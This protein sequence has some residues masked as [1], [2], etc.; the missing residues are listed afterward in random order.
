MSVLDDLVAAVNG[1]TKLDATTKSAVS[2]FLQ[3][4][5]PS[6]VTLAPVELQ[7]LLSGFA[8]G[9]V[10]TALQSVA[11]TFTPAQVADALQTTEQAMDAEVA[12]HA[13]TQ[14]AAHAALAA[15]QNAAVAILSKLVIAAL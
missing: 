6:L 3:T 1:S 14:A 13:Q 12:T 5:G 9:G 15:V 7:A 4:A 10:T 11:A 2:E 8:Q